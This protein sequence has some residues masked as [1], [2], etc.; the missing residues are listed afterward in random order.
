MG[1]KVTV[2]NITRLLYS[3]TDGTFDKMF[4]KNF[5]RWNT[6]LSSDLASLKKR[7]QHRTVLCKLNELTVI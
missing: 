7:T 1:Q 2:R 3:L 4:P 6:D 5:Y